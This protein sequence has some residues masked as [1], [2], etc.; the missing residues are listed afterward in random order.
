MSSI[1]IAVVTFVS[2]FACALLGIAIR[3]AMPEAHRSKESQDVVRLGMG[4]VATMTALLLGLI[5]AA[6]K[7]SFDSKNAGVRNSATN[8]VALDRHL[9]AYGPA[10][11]PIRDLLKRAAA[12]RIQ[13][14]WPEA[15]P[16]TGFGPRRVPLIEDIQKQVLALVPADD[17]QR[18]LRSTCLELTE[19][20]HRERWRLADMHARSV[21][22][23]FL[24][25][26]IFWLS[27]TFFSFGLYAPRN[28]TVVAGFAVATVSVAAAVFLILELDRPFEGLIKIPADSWRYAFDQLGM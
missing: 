19:Q 1:A 25:V 9:A 3:S 8:I 23:V 17:A 4:L 6:A 20:L 7:S 21:P 2:A 11:G 27:A 12:E 22:T 18:W 28:A 26:V 5:T 16:S 10:A 24:I 15:G 14:L 13:T